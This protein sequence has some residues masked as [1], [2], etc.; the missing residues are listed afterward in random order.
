MFREKL[1]K[2]VLLFMAVVAFVIIGGV[3]FPNHLSVL[4]GTEQVVSERVLIPGGQSVGIQM[5]VKGALI[6]GVENHSGPQVGDMIVAVNDQ[7]VEGPED[8]NAI[9][10]ESEKKVKL[11]VMRRQKMLHYDMTPYYDTESEEYKLG[12]WIKEKIAGI[13][14]PPLHC[15]Q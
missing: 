15:L 8:V 10:A 11:T 5:D 7:K 4:T 12:L 6:V 1:K 3:L 14:T 13:G 2:C 9:V